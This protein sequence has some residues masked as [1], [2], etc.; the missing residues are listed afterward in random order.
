MPDEVTV[1]D[2]V[3]AMRFEMV[4]RLNRIE[5]KMD[6]KADDARLDRVDTRLTKVEHEFVSRHDVEDLREALLSSEKVKEIVNDAMRDSD[7]RGWT[8]KERLMGIVIFAFGVINFFVG[9]LALG[10]DLLGG[11]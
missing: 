8:N 10:P 6:K 3:Q 2:L 7:A 9:I 11:K 5:D 4:E 1:K